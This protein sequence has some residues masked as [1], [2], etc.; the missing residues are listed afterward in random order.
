MRRIMPGRRREFVTQVR[1]RKRQRAVWQ[2]ANSGLG[3]Q[4]AASSVPARTPM[5][6]VH[7]HQR[8]NV[9]TRKLSPASWLALTLL[10]GGCASTQRLPSQFQVGD[11]AVARHFTNYPQLNGTHVRVTGEYKWRWIKGGNTLRCY[12]IET[13]DGQELAAQGFQLQSLTAQRTL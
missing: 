8:L 13:V 11:V 3:A 4:F 6:S 9:L 10:L 5:T 1:N 12:S 2:V 7:E